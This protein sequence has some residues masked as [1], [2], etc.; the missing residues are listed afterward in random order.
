M[1]RMVLGIAE[2]GQVYSELLAAP[3][4]KHFTTGLERAEGVENG[5]IEMERRQ[6]RLDRVLLSL[7]LERHQPSTGVEFELFWA[8]VGIVRRETELKLVNVEL[9]DSLHRVFHE[10]ATRCGCGSQ[11]DPFR[12]YIWPQLD[13]VGERP[14][15]IAMHCQFRAVDLDPELVDFDS[16]GIENLSHRF[17]VGPAANEL[18]RAG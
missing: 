7:Q 6:A 2:V 3:Q 11:V 9:V 13:G 1:V 8:F 10:L 5:G 14:G 15:C 12:R 17:S 18:P 4:L 16:F